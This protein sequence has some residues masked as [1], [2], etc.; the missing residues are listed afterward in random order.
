MNTLKNTLLCFLF[1]STL[2]SVAQDKESLK[3]EANKAY[4]A[5][6]NLDFDKIFETTYPKVFE[7]VPKEQMKKMF[8]QMMDNPEFS[9]KLIEVD[10]EFTFGDIKKIKNQ[11]FCVIEHNNKMK[12]IFKEALDEPEMMT[13]IFKSSMGATEVLYDKT[14]KS[15]LISIR[16][17]MIAVADETTKN[18][19]KFL[20]K[21]KGDKMFDMIFSEEVKK[22]LGL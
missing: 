1:L 9:I 11:T 13:D 21:D 10:P 20:N 6:A 14:D 7:I 18:E 3:K 5:A 15:Y 16:S 19:W 12:M 2:S 4:V 17:T 8:S 22:E